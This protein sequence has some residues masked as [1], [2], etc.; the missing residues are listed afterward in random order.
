M[1]KI[2]YP[3]AET[4][5][6][7]EKYSSRLYKII[8]TYGWGANILAYE[9]D[10]HWTLIDSGYKNTSKQ[11]K[12][13][14]HKIAKKPIE[15]IINSH[16]HG[17]HTGGNSLLSAAGKL[18]IHANL[19]KSPYELS[20]CQLVEDKTMANLDEEAL[21]LA[22]LAYGHST[23]DMIIIFKDSNVIFTGD[24]YLSESFPLVSMGKKNSAY[25][26]LDNLK[27]LYAYTD[28]KTL[29]VSGHGKDTGKQQLKA[30]IEMV[31]NTIAV[32]EEKIEQGHTK[33]EIQKMDVLKP[34]NQWNG[35]IDFITKTTWVEN[36]WRGWGKES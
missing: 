8:F 24:L 30:Y 32:V 9:G 29:L 10:K 33:R 14:L 28:N 1:E 2:F 35:N 21:E 23:T 12:E 6:F 20:Q 15:L 27:V 3:Q 5:V 16:Y 31:E 13:Q 4:R 26:L 19:K 7:L 25:T 36:I 18:M 34:W 11:L 22:P 17:D